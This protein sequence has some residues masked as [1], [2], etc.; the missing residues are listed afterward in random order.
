MF[1]F[2]LEP[3]LAD[4]RKGR[5]GQIRS[6]CS[7]RDILVEKKDPTAYEERVIR[8]LNRHFD[9]L[10]IHSDPEILRLEETFSRVADINIP[11]AYTGFIY[12][13]QRRRWPFR[14]QTA[15]ICDRRL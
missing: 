9:A 3:L 6:V 2:E 4:I 10:L 14:L 11:V 1:G 8:R 15:N 7:L 5:F 12:R 13:G